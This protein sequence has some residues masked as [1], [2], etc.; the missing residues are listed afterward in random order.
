MSKLNIFL[1]ILRLFCNGPFSAQVPAENTFISASPS[2]ISQW[3]LCRQCLKINY[4]TYCIYF[5][6]AKYRI[7]N[8]EILVSA[9]NCRLFRYSCSHV[10]LI[11]KCRMRCPT[12]NM[13]RRCDAA[14]GTALHCGSS[15]TDSQ[16]PALWV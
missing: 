12:P 4:K 16:T 15:D 9:N 7:Q 5:I 13:F 2:G 1:Q 6:F 10:P 8:T 3:L 11:M 14:S